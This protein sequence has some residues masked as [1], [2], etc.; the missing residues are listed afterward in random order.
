M[1]IRNKRNNSSKKA[2]QS[3]H[4]FANHQDIVNFENIMTQMEAESN[5]V[6]DKKRFS[7]YKQYSDK[8]KNVASLEGINLLLNDMIKNKLFPN[9]VILNQVIKKLGQYQYDLYVRR[10]YYFVLS[11]NIPNVVMYASVINALAKSESR[12]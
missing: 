10:I 1:N 9:M 3:S 11:K 8:L 2:N 12:M 7:D 4:F 6:I 5:F